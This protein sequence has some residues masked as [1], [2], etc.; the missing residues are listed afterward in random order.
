M[1]DAPSIA[2]IQTL[3]DAGAK[4]RAYDPEGMEAAR[5]VLSDVEYAAS[6]YAAAEGAAAPVIVTAWAALRALDLPRLKAAMADPLLVALRTFYR[7][8]HAPPAG[9]SY[10]GTAMAGEPVELGGE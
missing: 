1:R 3:Q 6:A 5:A 4:V 10:V 9:P 8:A 2:I 7:P